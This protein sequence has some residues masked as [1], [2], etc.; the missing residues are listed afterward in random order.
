MMRLQPAIAAFVTAASLFG[1]TLPAAAAPTMLGDTLT[2][3]RVYPSVSTIY[4]PDFT[5]PTTVVASGSA[6]AVQWIA[7][8]THYATIDPEATSLIFDILAGQYLG[9]SSTFDGYRISGFSHDID[10]VSLDYSGSRTIT[11]EFGIDAGVR[12][13]AVNLGGNETSRFTLNIEFAQSTVPEPQSHHLV[14]GALVALGLTSV[15]ARRH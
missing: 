8:G 9:S 4:P 5:P 10:A 1:A 14:F 2:F 6:D 11:P 7:N 13:V 12:Y 15:R 3:H